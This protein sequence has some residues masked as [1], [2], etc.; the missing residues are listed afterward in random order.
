MV[1]GASVGSSVGGS[2][3]GCVGGVV[4]ISVGFTVGAAVGA[5]VG[6]AVGMV[7]GSVGTTGSLTQADNSTV[8]ASRTLKTDI[9]LFIGTAPFLLPCP[10]GISPAGVAFYPIRRWDRI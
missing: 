9:S 3:G 4:G 7:V 6:A 8:S 10:P 5:V 2:V 1:V